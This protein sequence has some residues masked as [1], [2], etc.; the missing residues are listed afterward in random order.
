MPEE[1]KRK[2]GEEAGMAFYMMRNEL[3]AKDYTTCKLTLCGPQWVLFAEVEARAELFQDPS[4]IQ[5]VLF[6][7]SLS[8]LFTMD[9]LSVTASVAGIATACLMT[10]KTLNNLRSKFQDAQMTI[11]AIRTET[12]VIG[13]TLAKIQGILL[14]NPHVLTG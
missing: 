3:C 1:K 11:A 8:S 9:P 12:T 13:T 2:E 4:I 10:A 14:N 5:R 7:N 6:P